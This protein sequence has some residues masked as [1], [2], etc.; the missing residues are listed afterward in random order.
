ML[1]ITFTV[2]LLTLLIHAEAQDADLPSGKISGK[3]I[4]SISKKPVEYATI[5]LYPV[6]GQKVL[7]GT[8]TNSE[9]IF[10]MPGIDTGH[11]RITIEFIGYSPVTR[12]DIF[13]GGKDASIDLKTIFLIPNHQTLQ[14]VTVIASNNLIE[15]K[16][17]KLVFNAERDVTSVG[18][19]A[20]DILKKVPQVSVDVD[21][22][23]E[24][25]GSNS[26]RFLI[27]GKPSA[28]F[29]SNITDVLQSIPAS[30]VKS[31]EVI[32]N[33]GA[34]YDAQGLGG[35]INIILKDTRAKGINGNLSLTAGTR[36]E[37]GSLNINARNGDFGINAFVSGNFRLKANTP[38]SSDRVTMDTAALK[39]ISLLQAGDIGIIRH[40]IQAGIGFDWTYLKKNNFSGSVNYGNFGGT[41]SSVINQLQTTTDLSGATIPSMIATINRVR[42]RFDFENFDASLNYK[43]TFAREDR[44]L[45]IALD[46]SNES[47]TA[48]PN[49]LQS[50]LPQDSVF[51]GI[52]THNPASENETELQVDYT[53]PLKKDVILGLGGKIS[54]DQ[55]TSHSTIFAFEPDSKEYSF[56]SSL[57]NSLRYKQQVYALYEE[58]SFPI[59]H[60][61]DAKIGTRYERTQINSFFSNAQHQSPS[62]GYNTIVPSIFFS[63]KLNDKQ[64]IKL[65]YSKRI[66]RPDYGDLNP[67]INT[68]DPKNIS[69]GNPFLLPEIGHRF[70][71]SYTRNFTK[72]GSFMVTAMYRINAQDIQPFI[73][74]YPSLEVGDSSYTN[75]AVTTRQNI[76]KEHDLGVNIFFDIH[77]NSK[78]TLR[79]NLFL[80]HRHTFN[81]LDPGFNST[82]FNYRSNL[83][84][85]YQFTKDISAELFG[86]FSSPRH[87]AQG[88][89]PPF[90][91]YSLGLRK[92]LWKKKASIALSATNPFGKYVTQRTV[93]FG[94]NFTINGFRQLPFRSIGINFTWKFGKLEFKKDKEE[95]LD[96]NTPAPE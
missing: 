16:I 95:K 33:P 27:N 88:R 43:R 49:N 36:N 80:F 58:I 47:N 8:V 35:I 37:N 32:T 28:A 74:F 15:N 30:Q 66:E 1:R 44:V 7:N 12:N 90:T 55:I 93:L 91:T 3:I 70:E 57:S 17:D 87:E 59:G 92:Q 63:H 26:I 89:Y 81:V 71:L 64:T 21:G 2:F 38:Y 75:V 83:N 5:T 45:E 6:A 73:V 51:Y 52:M 46:N 40:G 62:K 86:G 18:G 22:N 78:F 48:N 96:T 68:S 34:K 76:G 56:D 69:S 41:N 53:E 60:F 42:N 82:S 24:L 25:A 77:V 20:T 79:S 50:L 61:L 72:A 31:I 94:P 39:E 11:F 19:V 10:T 84:T 13:I 23:V 14:N 65:S 9:G 67:F 4:D 54:F 85:S 29:G